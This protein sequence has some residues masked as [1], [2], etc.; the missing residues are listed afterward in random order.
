MRLSSIDPAAAT[1]YFFLAIGTAAIVYHIAN[2]PKAP[3]VSELGTTTHL[4]SLTMADFERR[5]TGYDDIFVKNVPD[6]V[7]DAN[8]TNT[9]PSTLGLN[10]I[11][12]LSFPKQV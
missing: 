8:S 1:L 9:L 7:R 6:T 2:Q 4:P 3:E 12:E 10:D 11:R 5:I